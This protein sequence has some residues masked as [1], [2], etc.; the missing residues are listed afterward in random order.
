MTK[1]GGKPKSAKRE[2]HTPNSAMSAV[3]KKT[4]PDADISSLSALDV[5]LFRKFR[6][7]LIRET[8][9]NLSDV[10]YHHLAKMELFLY[11]YDVL[12]GNAGMPQIEISYHE[13]AR[14]YREKILGIMQRVRKDG[15]AKR[16][17][18][19]EV[20]ELVLKIESES[21]Q[22]RDLDYEEAKDE[23]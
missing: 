3:A 12:V 21:G 19:D 15:D 7:R 20:K 2:S 9:D 4:S 11:H 10:E 8:G 22:I 18:L 6:A 13:T 16:P 23:E 5:G 1:N 17:V 14:K